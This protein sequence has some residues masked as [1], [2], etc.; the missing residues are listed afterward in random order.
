[1]DPELVLELPNDLCAI[2][3]A[4]EL[5]VWRCQA[6]HPH[7]R[8][9]RLNLRVG[10]TEALSNAMLYGNGRDPAK[11]VRIEVSWESGCVVTRVTDEGRGFDPGRV[12]DPTEP[13]N[14]SKVG[15][16]G[17]FL[18][19]ALMDE[20]HFNPAGNSVTLVLRFE[21]RPQGPG[22]PAASA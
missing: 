17:L 5:V 18:M 1:M 11:R 16:R 22:G 13:D 8:K 15:G 14:V 6:I 21:P 4:V 12:P 20:V 19:R 10:L 7:P 3:R 2:E 9:L